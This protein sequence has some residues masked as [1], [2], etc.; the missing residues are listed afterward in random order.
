MLI[1]A[2]SSGH[3]PLIGIAGKE[4]LSGAMQ[5]GPCDHPDAGAVGSARPWPMHVAAARP[6]TSHGVAEITPAEQPATASAAEAASC[7]NASRRR[8]TS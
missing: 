8:S 7:R 5:R 1:A 6:A 4:P 2:A 3:R